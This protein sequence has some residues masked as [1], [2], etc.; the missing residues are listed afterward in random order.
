MAVQDG[1]DYRKGLI[2][3]VAFWIGVG[4][5][6]D[7]VF[8]EHVSEFAGGLLRNG[9]TAGGLAVILMTLFV[10]TTKPRRSRIEAA[11]ELSV[12][13]KIREFLDVFASRSG[14]DAAMAERLDAACEETLL[15]LVRQ[16]NEEERRLRLVAYRE[17]GGAVLEFV[18]ASR[19]ENVQ[20][21]LALLGDEPGET[22][23]KEELSLQ[24]LRRLASSVR[25]QQYRGMDVVT[26]RVAGPGP[27]PAGGGET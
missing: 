24:L 15:T 3:G 21:Q 11:F 26:V 20:D 25:H 23:A 14:W 5:Q 17:G 18:V 4:F 1:L 2:V 13:P 9:V 16:E 22:P 12:L 19:D 7:L 10:E 8:P 6:S 27:A